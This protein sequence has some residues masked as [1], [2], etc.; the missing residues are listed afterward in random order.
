[1]IVENPV[2]LSKAL[3][4]TFAPIYNSGFQ[5]A[6][7]SSSYTF[8]NSTLGVPEETREIFAV[9]SWIPFDSGT[10]PRITSGTIN[11]VAV[12]VETTYVSYSRYLCVVRASV[13]TG[14][15]GNVVFNLSAT[16][17]NFSVL[18]Y[19]LSG[20]ENYGTGEYSSKSFSSTGV[21]ASITGLNV[22][23]GGFCLSGIFTNS[24]IISP[25]FSGLVGSTVDVDINA[26]SAMGS[27]GFQT[28]SSTATVVW[29][30]TTS[31]FFI[32]AAWIFRG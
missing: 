19:R 10:D 1:M 24:S 8:P 26:Y 25:S 17:S 12:T 11:G 9:V 18:L 15:T 2:L 22:P 28:S 20:R 32:S 16:C 6:Y 21:N 23:E 29:S 31:K 14:T 7:P 27:A 13:P 30:W 3:N 4:R 5:Y